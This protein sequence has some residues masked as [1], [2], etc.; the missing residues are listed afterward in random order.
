M[1]NV[2]ISIKHGCSFS[3]VW[4]LCRTI[5]KSEPNSGF[6]A[7]PSTVSSLAGTS[8]QKAQLIFV[9]LMQAPLF[10]HSEICNPFAK[11]SLCTTMAGWQTLSGCPDLVAIPPD[12]ESWPSS[13]SE[14][15]SNQTYSSKAPVTAPF[16]LAPCSQH[17]EEPSGAIPIDPAMTYTNAASAVVCTL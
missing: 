17:T 16:S 8:N 14:T 4:Y 1:Y 11:P 12:N 3:H 13:S 6:Y 9:S 5:V 2:S 15:C 7:P 10:G